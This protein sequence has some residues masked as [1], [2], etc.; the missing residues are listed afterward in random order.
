MSKRDLSPACGE[1]TIFEGLCG[2]TARTAQ[3]S[4]GPGMA[5]LHHSNRGARRDPLTIVLE[6]VN[7]HGK[8]NQDEFVEKTP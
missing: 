6:T 2:E 3:G 4:I 1:T 5:L 7:L 8:N